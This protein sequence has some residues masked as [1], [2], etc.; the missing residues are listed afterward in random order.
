MSNQLRHRWRRTALAAAAGAA[1]LAALAT[2]P[3]A[4][5]A[6][7]GTAAIHATQSTQAGTRTHVPWS[8]VGPGWELV[9]YT[10]RPAVIPVKPGPVTLYLVGPNGARYSLHT[11]PASAAQ[12]TLIA[13]SGDKTRALLEFPSGKM[14]QLTL[15][16]GRLSTFTMAG[17]ATPLGYTRPT[18]L[19]ILG[20][21]Q[22]GNTLRLARFSLTGQLL[23]VLVAGSLY[24]DTGLYSADGTVLAVPSNKGLLLVSNRGG[25]I[26]SLPVGGRAT[27]GCRP[28]AGGTRVP[29]SLPATRGPLR[30]RGCG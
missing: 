26:R 29:C 1:V 19:N 30:R 15:A 25:I 5:A 2:V 24:Y 17:H 13:W 20:V 12:P 10:T 8:K 3:R 16:T 18:G 9:Q 28:R 14:G 4:T 21:Q 22:V 6:T 11:W 23:K 7:A 27:A